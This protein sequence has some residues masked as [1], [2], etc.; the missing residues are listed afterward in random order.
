[1]SFF[2]ILSHLFG[3]SIF[4]LPIVLKQIGL[5]NFS[6][7]LVVSAILNLFML[8][9]MNKS[10]RALG[11]YYDDKLESIYALI[12]QSFITKSVI[13]AQVLRLSV[14]STIIIS[15]NMYMGTESEQVLCKVAG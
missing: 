4:I 7:G 12:K 14:L 5:I 2:H 13:F 6:I 1:V 11:T 3:F 8:W 15:L 9:E 10:E